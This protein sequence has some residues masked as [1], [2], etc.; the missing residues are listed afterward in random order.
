ML[1]LKPIEIFNNIWITSRIQT[2]YVVLNPEGREH[3]AQ[4]KD[5]TECG[6]GGSHEKWGGGKLRR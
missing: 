4:G 5:G 6:K 2:P 3:R 1:I